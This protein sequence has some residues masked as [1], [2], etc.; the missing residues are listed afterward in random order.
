MINYINLGGN[1]NRVDPLSHLTCAIEFATLL[2]GS[3]RMYEL[4][5]TKEQQRSAEYQEKRRRRR[6]GR[7]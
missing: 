7:A 3:Q 5:I 1:F 4:G 6:N 2:L